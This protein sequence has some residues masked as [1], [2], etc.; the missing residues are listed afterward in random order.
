MAACA[1]AAC[2]AIGIRPGCPSGLG[3]HGKPAGGRIS[4]FE[5]LRRTA[6][7]LRQFIVTGFPR[8]VNPCRRFSQIF[9]SF[10]YRRKKAE[11]GRH[12]GRFCVSLRARADRSRG[13]S[14]GGP[15][16]RS[17]LDDTQNRPLCL[18]C[19]IPESAP[20][21]PAGCGGSCRWTRSSRCGSTR[22]SRRWCRG[23]PAGSFPWPSPKMPRCRRRG[24][25]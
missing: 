6:A 19:V 21:R 7:Q 13:Y 12:R 18:V 15:S 10:S 22:G 23:R 11:G 3:R 16:T 9:E 5:R 24:P 25:R 20:R 4:G 8:I 2:A 14:V 17:R 1:A